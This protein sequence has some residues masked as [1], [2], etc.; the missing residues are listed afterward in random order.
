MTEHSNETFTAGYLLA[1]FSLE[2]TGKDIPALEAATAALPPGTPINVTFLGNEDLHMRVAAAAAVKKAGFHPVPHVSARRL[3][4][5]EDL[6]D[7]LDALQ[8]NGA[9]GHVF[10]VGGDP[11]IPMGPYPDA[12]SLINSGALEDFG[13]R[14]VSIAG[15]P[16]GH[17][18]IDDAT[19]WAA[20]EAKYVALRERGLQGEVI[21]QF[22]FDTI[23]V[24]DWLAEL[25]R[26]GID[27]PVRIGV[28][29]PAG[30]KR[31]LG[32]AR[33]FGVTSSAGIAKRYGFSLTNLLGTA[34]PERFIQDLARD[35]EPTLHGEIR[36]HFYTFGGLAAT[37][38]WV[39]RRL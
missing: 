19:L 5:R 7:F 11:A 28:P 26:R 22:G 39:A 27:L 9:A 15:Y 21:T 10:A 20:L 25:R 6:D 18:E 23:P 3:A 35:Y 30:I 31:L 37:A 16:E 33:R 8:T 1:G 38:D 29:G 13:I 17:A 14:T 36:L 34:G 32:Y 2:M 4:S 24:L 12:L